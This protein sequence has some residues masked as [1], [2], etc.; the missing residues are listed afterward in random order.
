MI[1][2]HNIPRANNSDIETVRAHR[3]DSEPLAS[4][5]FT[6]GKEDFAPPVEPDVHERSPHDSAHIP[7][8]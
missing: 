8:H 7:T 5:N 6:S 3:P 1:G 2:R 4:V